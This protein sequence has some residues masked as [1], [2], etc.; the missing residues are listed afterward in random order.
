MEAL[1]IPAKAPG[2][3]VLSLLSGL[4]SGPSDESQ[5]AEETL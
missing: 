2:E 1:A 5:R 4:V 3:S